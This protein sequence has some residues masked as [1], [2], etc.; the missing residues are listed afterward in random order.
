MPQYTKSFLFI[1]IPLFYQYFRMHCFSK[2][3]WRG[4]TLISLY[5]M[6]VVSTKWPQ[7]L[8]NIFKSSAISSNYVT[9]IHTKKILYMDSVWKPTYY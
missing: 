1:I 2:I 9:V 8:Y 5:N 4:H 7:F 6:D 3:N